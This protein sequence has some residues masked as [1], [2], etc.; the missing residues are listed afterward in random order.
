MYVAQ[1][2]VDIEV[3]HLTGASILTIGVVTRDLRLIRYSRADERGRRLSFWPRNLNVGVF[4]RALFR[5]L[6]N[7]ARENVLLDARVR[8]APESL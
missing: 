1:P 4:P 8:T 6:V 3:S 2:S 7:L 5:P